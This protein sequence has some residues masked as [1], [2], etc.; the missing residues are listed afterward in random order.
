MSRICPSTSKT[1][2]PGV[3]RSSRRWAIQFPT[4]STGTASWVHVGRLKPGSRLSPMWCL[5]RLQKRLVRQRGHRIFSAW[6]AMMGSWWK[7]MLLTRSI[8]RLG[9]MG[10]PV[11]T[12][13]HVGVVYKWLAGLRDVDSLT[14][15]KRQF[16]GFQ[17]NWCFLSFRP[18]AYAVGVLQ[19]WRL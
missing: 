10:P 15:C 2:V 11:T 4:G 7:L 12:P 13:F 17:W 16:H 1:A 3:F 14:D 19:S 9:G 5:G 8:V 6:L 18:V